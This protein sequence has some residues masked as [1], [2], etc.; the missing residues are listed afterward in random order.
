MKR[1]LSRM[2]GQSYDLLEQLKYISPLAPML[3]GIRISLQG[4]KSRI[5]G[6]NTIRKLEEAG[7]TSVEKVTRMT[8]LELK[9]LGVNPRFAKQIIEYCAEHSLSS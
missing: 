6:L 9:A 1:A 4:E 8:L 3:R 2:R 7:V 5:V